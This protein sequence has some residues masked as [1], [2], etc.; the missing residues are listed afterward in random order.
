LLQGKSS[1][2]WPSWFCTTVQAT[3]PGEEAPE[4]EEEE[5]EEEEALRLD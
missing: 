5:E 3:L 1:R 2:G 4:E